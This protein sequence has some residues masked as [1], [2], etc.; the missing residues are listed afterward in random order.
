MNNE[1]LAINIKMMREHGQS[2]KYHHEVLGH[3]YRMEGIQGAVLGVKLKYLN[4]WTEKRRA[5]AARYKELLA[6]VEEIV[7]PKEMPY[8]RHVYHLFVIRVKKGG[9]RR[10][11]E[12]RRDALMKYLNENGVATGLHYPVPLHLQNCFKYLDYKKGDFPVSEELAETGLSLP[13]YPEMSDEQV[14]YVCGVVRGF[15]KK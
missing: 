2:E 10:E 3:N 9:G 1:Q 7:L 6:G 8:A 12:N 13:M 11:T 14:E 15:L 5:V 4:G